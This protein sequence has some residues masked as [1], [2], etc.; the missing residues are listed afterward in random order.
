MSW[1]YCLKV[2][3]AV[4]KPV[5]FQSI[6]G[7]LIP[8]N[9]PI[10]VK[11]S[12]DNVCIVGSTKNHRDHFLQID[13]HNWHGTKKLDNFLHYRISSTH[14]HLR[15]EAIGICMDCCETEGKNYEEINKLSCLMSKR[16]FKIWTF[17]NTFL[18][19]LWLSLC[20]CSLCSLRLILVHLIKDVP[21]TFA[22]DPLGAMFSL[23]GQLLSLCL[24]A[25]SLQEASCGHLQ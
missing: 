3:I 9:S 7:S 18:S 17:K 5:S 6:W 15:K 22:H 14:V 25:S 13:Q 2:L 8:D 16:R 10:L 19:W 12:D 1:Q 24:A 23:P 21:A 4:G 20:C 11:W